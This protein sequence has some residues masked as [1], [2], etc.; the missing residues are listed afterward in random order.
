MEPIDFAAAAEALLRNALHEAREGRCARIEVEVSADTLRVTDDGP[1]L[2]VHPH[3]RS[4]RPLTEVILTGP[5]RGPTNT[6]ARL[7]AHCTW[8]EVEVHVDGERWTQRY[9]LAL[10]MGPLER[11]G[12]TSRRGT[13]IACAPVLGAPPAL[14]D[15]RALLR[16]LSAEPGP[17]PR[18]EVRLRDLRE[19][20]G[21]ETIVMA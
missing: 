19:P 11:R 21:G 2:P 1:G 3:P 6:L 12:P 20:A 17:P 9:E 8:L 10:P 13:T 15:L 4:G 16:A 5:R 14:D 7:N 18:V